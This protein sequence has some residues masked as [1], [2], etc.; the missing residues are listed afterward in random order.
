[1]ANISTYLSNNL[2]DLG[3]GEGTYAKPTTYLGLFT[4]APTMPAGT[5]GVEVSGGSYARVA[6]GGS[7]AAAASE[8]IASNA[9]ITFPAATASWGTVTSIGIFDA[10]TAGNLLWAGPLSSSA[11][12]GSGDT[13]TVPSGSLTGSLS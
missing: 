9:A 11:T 1:M 8:L 6:I 10:L 3:F 12:V 5:G 2:L 13:F 4:T 7:M